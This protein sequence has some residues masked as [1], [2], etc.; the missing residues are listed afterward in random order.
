MAT[1]ILVKPTLEEI[2]LAALK[3]GL[4]EIEADKFFY[5]YESNG[6]RVGRVK[7]SS[8]NGAL[9]GWKIRWQERNGNREDRTGRWIKQKEYDRICDRLKL[10]NGTYAGHQTWAERDLA[11]KKRLLA[12]R[13]QLRTELGI[14]L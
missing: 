9:A 4:P 8:L 13:E 11:E 14:L 3:I 12:K 10:L 1:P 2:R 7:M 6:W 5:H